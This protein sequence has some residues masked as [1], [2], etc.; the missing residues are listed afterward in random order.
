M[1]RKKF[2]QVSAMGL[3][4]LSSVSFT[5]FQSKIS[6]DDLMGKG[7]PIIVGEGY[8]LRKKANQAFL[9]MKS[10]ALKQGIKIKV[11]SSYRDYA[12]Q[13]RIWERKYERYTASGLLPT[14]AIHKIIEYSTIPGTSRHHWGSDIDIVDGSVKQPKDVLLEKHFHN[15]GPFA[16]F[17]TWMDHNANDFGFYLVYTNKK[18]RKGF[19]YEPWHYSYAPT[20]IPM[21]KEFKK[22]DIKTELQKAVLMGSSHFSSEFI[23]QYL[24]EN[25]LDINPKLL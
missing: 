14:K 18:G 22:L 2:I 17:K 24:N 1:K 19:K 20:S 9:K 25:I 5:S 16:R 11:V 4:G 12:H 7:N 23:Q 13:N 8:K 10:A 6:K 21:L 15:D 3:V